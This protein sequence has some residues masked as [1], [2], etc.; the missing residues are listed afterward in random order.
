[1]VTKYDIFEVMYKYQHPIRPIEIL[2]ILS[3]NKREYNNIIRLVHEL[4]N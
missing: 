2:K 4:L 3:K 1:M